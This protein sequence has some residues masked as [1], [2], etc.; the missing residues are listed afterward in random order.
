MWVWVRIQVLQA[1]SIKCRKTV[2]IH[3][4]RSRSI[5]VSSVVDRVISGCKPEYIVKYWHTH[6]RCLKDFP[7]LIVQGQIHSRILIRRVKWNAHPTLVYRSSSSL[8]QSSLIVLENGPRERGEMWLSFED[9]RNVHCNWTWISITTCACA[10]LNN[11]NDRV[12]TFCNIESNYS[13][14]INYLGT[15][16]TGKG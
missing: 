7:L 16:V 1:K 10:W 9:Q 4:I 11:C 8:E 14:E 15:A 13:P 5:I 3:L 6:C 12:I 2:L